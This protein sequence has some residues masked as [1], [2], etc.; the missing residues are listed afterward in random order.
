TPVIGAA[1]AVRV[2]RKGRLVV[3]GHHAHDFALAQPDS[4]GVLD[5]TF[6]VDGT[7]I[8]PLSADNWDEAQGLELEAHGNILVG[9]R[10]YEGSSSS[11]N[12]ALVRN[13]AQGELDPTFGN[14]GVV[15]TEVAA[16]AKNDIASAIL[17]Q[18]DDRVP[19]CASSPPA[20]RTPRTTTSPW[21]ATGVEASV[22]EACRHRSP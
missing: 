21:H 17:L 1:R 19:P 15:I 14:D 13:S 5:P 16:T 2:T 7:Q 9:G 12:V 8:T 20:R 4:N 10:E 22:R 3:A 6:G 11:G 18:A